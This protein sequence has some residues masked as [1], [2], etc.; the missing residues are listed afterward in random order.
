[1][2][3]LYSLLLLISFLFSFEDFS[4]KKYTYLELF[5]K[6]QKELKDK[7]YKELN[8]TLTL[9]KGYAKCK[10]VLGFVYSYGLGVEPNESKAINY[11][12]EAIDEGEVEASYNLGTLYLKQKE[13]K[14]AIKYLEPI[15]NTV[16]KSSYNLGLI[17][18]Y[19][20]E[21]DRNYSMSLDY[22][23]Q[24]SSLG[25]TKADEVIKYLESQI[26]RF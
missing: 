7:N 13:Y 23:K 6:A 12:Q 1:M 4:S 18:L 19:G 22:M 16:A 26:E 21:V 2:K 15:A 3:I 25:Y 14:K 5:N 9:C 8:K 17:Y 24:A 10:T 11:F 20:W